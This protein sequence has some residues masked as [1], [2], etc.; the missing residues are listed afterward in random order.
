MARPHKYAWNGVVIETSL[1]IEQIANM[2]QRAAQESTGDLLKGKQRIVSTRSAD[3]QIEF[4]INDFLISFSK[5]LVFFLE[6]EE[7][8][9]RTF[10]STRIEWYLTTQQ[11]VAGIVPVSP[12]KM[13]AHHTYMQFARNLADQVRAADRS[14]KVMLREG[15]EPAAAPSGAVPA[16]NNQPAAPAPTLPPPPPP[17]PTLESS[18]GSAVSSQSSLPRVSFAPLPPERVPVLPSHRPLGQQ[19]PMSGESPVAA[20]QPPRL[21]SGEQSGPSAAPALSLVTAVPGFSRP[22]EPERGAPPELPS[23]DATSPATSAHRV[24]TDGIAEGDDYDLEMTR[25]ANRDSALTW[26]LVLPDFEVINLDTSAVIGRNPAVPPLM[27]GAA[28]VRISDHTH[29]VSKT[30][31]ALE[32]R[33]CLVWVTDLHSTNGTVLVNPNGE[34]SDCSPGQPVPAGDGWQVRFGD[35]AVQ[36]RER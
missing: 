35:F 36:L 15:T 26:E 21:G 29:S 19:G 14:A 10:A 30:H 31:A 24:T 17:P 27:P 13:V 1:S 4:R 22:T 28:L 16:T 3:R 2:S 18:V 25:R 11:T 32:V 12:K 33:D 34:R 5:L 23:S 7:R 9:G 8:G 20:P 6:F